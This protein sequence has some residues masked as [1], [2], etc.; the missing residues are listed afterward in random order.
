MARYGA[1]VRSITPSTT[2]DNIG[3]TAGSSKSGKIVEVS[4]GGESTTTTAMQTRVARSS[5]QTGA[6]TA[7]TAAKLH[8]NAPA[9]GMVFEST[10]ATTQPTLD[11]GDLF[12]TSW[13]SHGGV[14]RWLA[15]PGEE[16]VIIGAA[17]ETVISCR[18][19]V[20]TGVSTYGLVTEED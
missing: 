16:F 2:D 5:G 4:W 13:N 10:F 9:N 20:G 14:V 12:T 3:V 18:N 19:S 15:A 6:T 7:V 17:T 11:T 8:P 1:Y